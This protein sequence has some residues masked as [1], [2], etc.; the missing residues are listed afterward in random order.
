MIHDDGRKR[1]GYFVK[2]TNFKIPLCT[3]LLRRFLAYF[4]VVQLVWFFLSNVYSFKVGVGRARKTQAWDVREPEAEQSL[5]STKPLLLG[6][7][8]DHQRSLNENEA[9]FGRNVSS[10]SEE[11]SL[12][13][14]DESIIK[15]LDLCS[16]GTFT[17]DR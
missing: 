14:N 3:H 17:T 6:Q 12:P 8:K 10:L 15:A 16:H 11:L 4:H 7:E 9:H 5:G 13:E 1:I 2:K